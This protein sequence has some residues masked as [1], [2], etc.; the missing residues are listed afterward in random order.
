MNGPVP[1]GAWLTISGVPAAIIAS[2]YSLDTIEA[3]SIAR[4]ATNAASGRFRVNFTVMSSTFSIDLTRSGMD[5]DS[6]YSQVAPLS[7]W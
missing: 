6:K 2:A 7:E 4:S 3:K 1:I 5:I